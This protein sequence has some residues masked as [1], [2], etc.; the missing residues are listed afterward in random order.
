MNREGLLESANAAF[1]NGEWSGVLDHCAPLVRA[2]QTEVEGRS[3]MAS[4]LLE[5]HFA[6]EAKELVEEAALVAPHNPAVACLLARCYL[7]GGRFS[8]AIGIAG[9]LLAT[10][11]DDPAARGCMTQALSARMNLRRISAHLPP[12]GAVPG[13][14]R[15]TYTHI[16]IVINCRDRVSGVHLLIEWLLRAGYQYLI[17]L[18]NNSTYPPL[19]RYYAGLKDSR[20]HI[21]R[22]PANLGHTAIWRCGLASWFGEVPFV[23]TDPDVVPVEDCPHGAIQHL[24]ELLNAH[25]QASKAGLSLRIDDLPACFAHRDAVIAHESPFWRRPL[26]GGCYDAP[27]D[28]TFALYRPGA[29]Y[30]LT[31]VRAA[32][33]YSARHLP[34][35]R[36]SSVITDEDRYYL[37]H[38]LP[39]VSSWGSRS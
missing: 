33:P 15:G 7:E 11:P 20:I 26:S 36:D 28:T 9:D 6:W 38:G 23:Y 35:Y 29:W 39:G 22:L 30:Q 27:V 10:N 16:P 25:P 5:L 17:L 21:R 2:A 13:R 34:W 19:L 1:A 18:D 8:E 24:R 32:C 37:A 12:A 4:A 31:A 3:L 14:S